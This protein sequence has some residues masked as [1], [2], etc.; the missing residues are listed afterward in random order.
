M[1]GSQRRKKKNFNFVS[2]FSGAGI[3]DYGL[4]LAGGV[5]L[6]ACEIDTQRAA[7]HT[8]NFKKHVWGDIRKEKVKIVESLKDKNIDLIIATPPCQS[9]STANSRRGLRD[10]AEHAKGDERNSLFFEALYIIRELNP[11]FVLFENVPNFLMKKI[12]CEEEKVTSRVHE[13]I[14]ASLQDY[15]SWQGNI[16]FSKF[17]VPQT[18]KRSLAFFARRDLK[19]NKDQLAPNNWLAKIDGAPSCILEAI[20][21]LSP[22]DGISP[23]V[24]RDESDPL[25]QVPVYSHKHYSWIAGIPAGS[26]K[27]AWE[28]N[29][30]NC[31]FSAAPIFTVH[32]PS[33]LEPM[34]NRPHVESKNGEIRA[35]KGFKTSYKRMKPNELAN[36]IT[37]SS[38]TF[39]S[40]V[41]L[42]PLQNRVLSVR[43]CARLQ[44]IPDSFKW[45]QVLEY[46][47]AHLFR[48]M[49]GEAVPP[50]VTYQLGLTLQSLISL[51]T[52]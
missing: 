8:A 20:S 38:G 46:R 14:E 30:L 23:T 7:V 32:C 28:N 11:S 47:K 2:L 37:T 12:K 19:I 33:C 5:C 25:H 17:G 29:C 52:S 43:E 6:A 42:H 3:G 45:P 50:L 44:T 34:K 9:F 21:D 15:Q 39:S 41:K 48:E 36:T 31:G 18:R 24:A 13:F 49:I 35:I 27:S 10:D 16:C 4:H 1:A 26:G 40:D 22:L 51:K